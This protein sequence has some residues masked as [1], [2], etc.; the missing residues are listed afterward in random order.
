MFAAKPNPGGEMISV[1]RNR[2]N[3]ESFAANFMSGLGVT[4]QQDNSPLGGGVWFSTL[5]ELWIQAPYK[6][7]LTSNEL[8]LLVD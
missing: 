1:H 8:Q 5:G 7:G 2:W 6:S 3:A 4:W